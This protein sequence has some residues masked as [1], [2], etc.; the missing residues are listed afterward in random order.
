MHVTAQCLPVRDPIAHRMESPKTKPAL[1]KHADIETKPCNHAG[2]T[3]LKKQ[4]H[5][6][7]AGQT[8]FVIAGQLTHQLLLGCKV[9]FSG[10]LTVP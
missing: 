5:Y 9:A 3:A 10:Y 4:F 6:L 8:F 7:T 2:E 1:Q